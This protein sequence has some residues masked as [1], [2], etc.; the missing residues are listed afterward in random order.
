MAAAA[1]EL[2]LALAAPVAERDLAPATTPP[3]AFPRR[4]TAFREAAAVACA[5]VLPAAA[6]EAA[7]GCMAAV[8]ECSMHFRDVT[9]SAPAINLAWYSGRAQQAPGVA[10]TI[11]PSAS[12]EWSSARR[13]SGV[14][15]SRCSPG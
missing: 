12:G 2:T 6:V 14:L 9:S 11:A 7:A 10:S 4:L 13:A 8:S 5:S 3:L 1:A 15:E